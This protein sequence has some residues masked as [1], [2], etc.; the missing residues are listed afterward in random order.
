[1]PFSVT[2]MTPIGAATPGNASWAIAP[3]SSRTNHGRT[4]RRTSS[5]TASGAAVPNTSSSQPKDSQTSCAGVKPRSSSVS[6]ASQIPTRQP[7]SSRV[8][9]PQIAPSAIVA[10]NGGC[11]QGAPSST[12]TTSRCAISTT[13]RSAAWPGPAEEQARGCGSGSA[14]GARAAAGTGPPARRGTSSN[15]AVS[16]RAGSGWETV[17]MR[18]RACSLPTA[19]GYGSTSLTDMGV[20]LA[21]ARA[22]ATGNGRGRV[23]PASRA[24]NVSDPRPP[25]PSRVVDRRGR[26]RWTVGV[27]VRPAPGAAM[28]YVVER[29]P[30]PAGR[31]AG[32]A[33]VVGPVPDRDDARR[34]RTCP[35]CRTRA[36]TACSRSG[37]MPKKQAPRPSSTAVCRISRLA[38]AASMCQNGIGQRASSRSVQPLSGSAYRSR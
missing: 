19:R 31:G 36:R 2:P 26:R 16:T 25:R 35:G 22:A 7:L 33:G 8:P 11:C 34:G 21:G 5:A 9:R 38:I 27:S 1:M 4:P 14:R 17:G 32:V 30:W 37:G 10:P 24:G 28:E 29:S 13:G 12:G 18:T 6:T 23:S 3:P 15:G 20:R